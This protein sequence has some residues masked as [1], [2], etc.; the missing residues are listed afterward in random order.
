MTSCSPVKP[1]STAAAICRHWSQKRA[2]RIIRSGCNGSAR[3]KEK[4]AAPLRGEQAAQQLD[5]ALRAPGAGRSEE[6]LHL[7]D[8]S[9][10]RPVDGIELHG[11]VAEQGFGQLQQGPVAI[12]SRR[13]VGTL[14]GLDQRRGISISQ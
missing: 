2:Q 13:A 6:A 12:F 11:Q 7:R 4:W 1:S 14:P 3:S 9:L 10:L 8:G 5:P